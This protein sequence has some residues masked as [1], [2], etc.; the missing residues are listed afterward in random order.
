MYSKIVFTLVQIPDCQFRSPCKCFIRRTSTF[1]EKFYC[2][3]FDQLPFGGDDSD[4]SIAFP[5]QFIIRK[6]KFL[7]ITRRKLNIFIL[8]HSIT[9]FNVKHIGVIS[10]NGKLQI[11]FFIRR[12]YFVGIPL[13]PASVYPEKILRPDSSTI[14][15]CTFPFVFFII[16]S[17][18]L[19]FS[20]MFVLSRS[21]T[22][23]HDR[24]CRNGGR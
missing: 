10:S 12:K 5:G 7:R 19:S 8:M 3:F 13:I 20:V 24:S 17:I 15:I 2:C 4:R 22:V 9:N 23:Q 6:N 1:P 16:G 14:I 18:S 11:S 21:S